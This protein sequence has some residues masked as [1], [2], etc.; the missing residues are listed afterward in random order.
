M[1][2]LKKNPF[3]HVMLKFIVAAEIKKSQY[4]KNRVII[5]RKLLEKRSRV[6]LLF[7]FCPKTTNS[8]IVVLFSIEEIEIS[9]ESAI[10][11]QKKHL[12]WA[13]W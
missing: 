1:L 10:A 5:A 2:F 9:Y 11:G 12:D 8:I 6:K 3:G 4:Q 13:G 7:A